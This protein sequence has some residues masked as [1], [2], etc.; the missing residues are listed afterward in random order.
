MMYS[1]QYQN[2]TRIVS[3]TVNVNNDD[4]VLGCNTSAGAVIL[5]LGAIPANRWNTVWKLYVVDSSNNASVNNIT[6]NAGSGQTINGASS[7]V[8]STNGGGAL[9]RILTN[10]SFIATLSSGAGGG[11]G[12]NTVQD[13]GSP[14][15]QRTTIDFVGAGVTATDNGSKT[16]VTISGGGASV[17]TVSN[18][19]LNNL[20]NTNAVVAGQQYLVTPVNYVNGAGVLV[21]GTG[22][23]SVSSSGI[24]NFLNA[25]YQK[26]GNY[27]GVSGFTAIIGIWDSTYPSFTVGDVVIYNNGHYKNLTGATGTAPNVDTTNW[28]Y[29]TP[30]VTNGYIAESDYVIYNSSPSVNAIVYREDKR[31]NKVDLFVSGLNN[32]LIDFQWGRDLANKNVIQGSSIF[33]AT[34]SNASFISNVLDSGRFYSTTTHTDAGSFLSNVIT[35][36]SIFTV[37]DNKSNVRYNEVISNSSVEV[38]LI[39][40][41]AIFDSNTVTSGGSIQIS[42]ELKATGVFRKNFVS[43]S[44]FSFVEI[45]QA[46]I[47]SNKLSNASTF[48]FTGNISLI[49]ILRNNLDSNGLIDIVTASGVDIMDKSIIEDC[50][51]TNNASFITPTYGSFLLGS[52]KMRYCIIRNHG[53]VVNYINGFHKNIQSRICEEGYSNWQ[54]TLDFSDPTICNPATLAVTIP[55][56]MTPFVGEFEC[57]N[58]PSIG[59]GVSSITNAPTLHP[60]IFK[61]SAIDTLPVAAVLIAG[62]VA[63]DIVANASG[64][65]QAVGRVNGCDRFTFEVFGN[66]VGLTQQSLFV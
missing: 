7:L 62:A 65:L 14:L 41:G 33:A 27:S 49:D 66:L 11:G 2:P 59:I 28:V 63:N 38:A 13:E 56:W 4:V 51:V 21:T 22:T 25:D 37:T 39:G 53:S 18:A 12:Y 42:G 45:N 5:N 20:I 44:T 57:L 54:E 64:L 43:Q 6:I 9:I 55:T 32:T 30:S 29:L 50:S 23:N 3:G 17:T 48:R 34:N 36:N 61:P 35:G 16:I 60:F 19:Q 46:N 1:Q 31:E 58:I 52:G 26:V 24:G 40:V 47:E 8:I 10:T 15:P